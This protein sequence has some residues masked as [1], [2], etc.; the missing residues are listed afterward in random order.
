ML[1]KINVGKQIVFDRNMFFRF[2]KTKST[3]EELF[4][5]VGKDQC[6]V[7][8]RKSVRNLSNQSTHDTI[9]FNSIEVSGLNCD[10]QLSEQ[11][12]KAALQPRPVDEARLRRIAQSVRE[13]FQLN[14]LSIDILR[15]SNTNDYVVVDV[16]YFPCYDSM[17]DAP[18][19]IFQLC[20]SKLQGQ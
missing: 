17:L 18:E 11:V 16:N 4:I 8:E 15:V 9:A 20:Q 2:R 3:E 1:Y 14:F 7:V 19:R 5:L 13:Q 12:N 6:Q 10:H